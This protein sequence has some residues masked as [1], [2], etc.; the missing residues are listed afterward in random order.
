M[1]KKFQLISNSPVADDATTPTGLGPHGIALWKSVN[2]EYALEDAGGV[3][4][5]TQAC[6][7]LDRAEK[8]RAIIDHDG[9]L[10]RVKGGPPR[11]HPLLKAELAS[12]SF[13]VRTLGRMGLCFEPMRMTV[14]RPP[15]FA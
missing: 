14:G 6:M 3:A 12:R 7:A 9:E 13:C 5:L 4:M 1:A 8:C 2:A 15:G 10:I 11:E